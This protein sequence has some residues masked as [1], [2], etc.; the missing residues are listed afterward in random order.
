MLLEL[1]NPVTLDVALTVQQQLHARLD[2]SD[3]LRKQHVERARYAE[4]AQ[5]RYMRVDPEN[6]LV[7]DSLE[8]EFG[9]SAGFAQLLCAVRPGGCNLQ[10][11]DSLFVAGEA[12][13]DWPPNR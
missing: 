10:P 2:E 6:R 11:R 13:W 7:A 5:R 3:R 12:D 1:I 9:I 4:M 8:A